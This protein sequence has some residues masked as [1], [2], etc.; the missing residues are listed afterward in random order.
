MTVFIDS[1]IFLRAIL[2]DVPDQ[3][4]SCLT[5]FEMIDRGEIP[6][7][8]SML[9]LNEILWVLEGLR[10]PRDEIAKRTG[11]IAGSRVRLLAT[12]DQDFVEA[13]IRLYTAKEVDFQDALN[14]ETARAEDIKV[15]VSYDSHFDEIDFVD[16]KEP[17]EIIQEFG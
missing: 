16:R 8:T 17:D 14:A 15:I 13:A 7:C 10:V 6:S 5:L 3:A 9:V 4:K 11:A 1:N 2:R 12:S